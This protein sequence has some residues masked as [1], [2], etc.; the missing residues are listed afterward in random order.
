[1]EYFITN[2]RITRIKGVG[3]MMYPTELE[4]KHGKMVVYMRENLKQV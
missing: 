4:N 1:M 2:I 3:E